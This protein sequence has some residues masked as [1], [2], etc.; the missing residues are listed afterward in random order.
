MVVPRLNHVALA[1]RDPARSLR[2]Y[3]D[4]IGVEGA[5]R[6]ESYGFVITTPEGVTFT[7]FQGEPPNGHGAF[8]VGVG[9]SDGEAV[10]VKRRELRAAAVP[11]IEWWDEEDYVSMKVRDP[12]GYAVEVGWDEKHAS[13]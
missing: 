11:E 5:V 6:E 4:Q 2:F 12:D 10:R 7:L 9:L 1:V 8:H 3:R 13:A